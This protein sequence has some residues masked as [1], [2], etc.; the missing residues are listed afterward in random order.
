MRKTAAED[1]TIKV[2]MLGGFS[3]RYRGNTITEGTGRA[4]KVWAL[5]E[6]LLANRGKEI[7]QEKLIEALW[8]GEECDN[9]LKNLVY[10]ARNT[11]RQLCPEDE[12]P[13]DFIKYERNTYR[14]NTELPC[15]VDTEEFEKYYRIAA[16][17]DASVKEQ[18]NASCQAIMLYQGQFL[19]KSSYMDWVVVKDAY[20]GTLFSNCVARLV[21]LIMQNSEYENVIRLCEY[22]ISFNPYE[23]HIHRALLYAYSKTGQPKKV[24]EHYKYMTQ[25]FYK[26]FGVS[27]SPETVKLYKNIVKVMH[28]IELDLMAIKEDLRETSK[29]EGAFYCDYD[30]FKNIYR[31]QARSILRTGHPVQIGL[32][33]F[34]DQ[35]EDDFRPEVICQVMAEFKECIMPILRKGDVVSAYSSTQLVIMLP[36]TTYE[37]GKKVFERIISNFE[38]K[39]KRMD[40]KINTVLNQVDPVET[41]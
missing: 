13:V 16:H 30:V 19:P 21:D 40:I 26:E 2:Q 29:L 1:D 17:P 7:P 34:T 33:T 11:L 5:I 38:Q 15:V 27:L 22:S 28:N 18:V 41:V 36:M 14:W 37:N 3:I 8:S 4:K 35:E 20:F 12:N 10:R 31:L 9:P 39:T 25:A 23:E 32:I 24:M 6:F